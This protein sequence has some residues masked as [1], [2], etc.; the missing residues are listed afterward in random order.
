MRSGLVH[1]PILGET[2]C[3]DAY[4]VFE[5]ENSAVVVVA[6]GLG[7]GPHAHAASEKAI[8]MVACNLDKPVDALL[9]ACHVA[10]R[11]TRGA[12]MGVARIDHSQQTLTYSGVG[13]IEARVVGTDKVRRPS[14]VN[15]IVGYNARKFNIDTVPFRPGDML[16]MHSDGVSDRFQ[17]TPDVRGQD[18]QMLA[19]QLVAAHGRASDDQLMLIVMSEP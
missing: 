18:P 7:H 4:G 12:V 3:G 17:L 6:D 10:L 19:Y 13:N 16:L 14:S 15:G 5:A 1:R 2:V 11:S 9:K 8:A